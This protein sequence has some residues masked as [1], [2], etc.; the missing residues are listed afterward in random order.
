MRVTYCVTLF[1]L[2]ISRFISASP[3]PF[4]NVDPL[5]WNPIGSLMRAE[6]HQAETYREKTHL[7][8]IKN[9]NVDGHTLS[10]T[11][12]SQGISEATGFTL[13]ESPYSLRSSTTTT[14]KGRVRSCRRRPSTESA[15]M[16]QTSTAQDP[17]LFTSHN[18]PLSSTSVFNA[19]TPLYDTGIPQ[20]VAASSLPQASA[21]PWALGFI[22]P[23]ILL[24]IIWLAV[25]YHRRRRTSVPT[26]IFPSDSSAA[27]MN[28]TGDIT[29]K[30]GPM[31]QADHP[32]FLTSLP[33]IPSLPS[34]PPLGMG[35][36]EPDS[37]AKRVE[38][39]RDR[40]E[41]K[42]ARFPTRNELSS[43]VFPAISAGVER[44]VR[45]LQRSNT[46]MDNE[47]T[48]G[49]TRSAQV[50]ASTLPLSIQRTRVTPK[51]FI[52]R[53]QAPLRKRISPIGEILYST[54]VECLETVH[55]EATPTA[56][57]DPVPKAFYA[58]SSP[59]GLR[60]RPRSRP[61]IPDAI[62]SVAFS[63]PLGSDG[64]TVAPLKINKTTR[65]TH[66]R[67]AT[68]PKLF[69]NNDDPEGNEIKPVSSFTD[70]EER[71]F[72]EFVRELVRS[73]EAHSRRKQYKQRQVQEV[74]S[75]VIPEHDDAAVEVGDGTL[76]ELATLPLPSSSVGAA[77]S[78][79]AVSSST[80]ASGVT[81]TSS[82][83]SIGIAL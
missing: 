4:H 81:S 73:Q 15:R 68:N 44:E 49:I 74:P 25:R 7:N 31:D 83:Y 62:T 5:S 75:I 41:L 77:L 32:S 65:P 9:D 12:V 21:V 70:E 57:V 23:S 51:P 6:A 47:E 50:P 14:T 79:F 28:K 24:C 19:P 37:V 76:G 26:G 30:D 10:G 59:S 53:V 78:D 43:Y 72:A 40:F 8:I 80:L 29:E 1:F 71:K 42:A 18:I 39:L 82:R 38:D 16:A 45:S 60:A 33:T 63:S 69:G 13:K 67:S 64:H 17:A 46:D 35:M 34:H 22:L 48:P 66:R 27:S 61:T 3:L 54:G 52:S 2:L 58:T 55:E 56:D 20:L 11:F 36:T